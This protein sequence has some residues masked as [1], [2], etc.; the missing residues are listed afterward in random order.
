M[1]ATDLKRNVCIG[2]FL[3][4]GILFMTKSMAQPP[5]PKGN[6]PDTK[7]YVSNWCKQYFNGCFEG[8]EFNKVTK[9]TSI[10][11]KNGYKEIQGELV[12]LNIL[13]I[14]QGVK[15]WMN[16]YPSYVRFWKQSLGPD[17]NGSDDWTWQ[18]EECNS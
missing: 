2:I 13:G 1:Q 4:I 11:R 17:P 16:V 10:K 15:F 7:R 18:W 3:L 9:I 14:P 5:R 6:Y 12:Y 8:R